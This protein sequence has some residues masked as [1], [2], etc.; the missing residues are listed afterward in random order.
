MLISNRKVNEVKWL[1][2]HSPFKNSSLTNK[3]EIRK[4]KVLP[5]T[6]NCPFAL[7]SFLSHNIDG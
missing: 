3:A 4:P 1:T 2:S 6:K 7:A 5:Q